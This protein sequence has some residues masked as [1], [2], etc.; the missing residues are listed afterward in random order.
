MRLGLIFRLFRSSA[1]IQRKRM[2]LTVIAIAWGTVSIVMLLAFGEG[3]KR[4][5]HRSSRGTGEG[6]LIIWPGE[7]SIAY[8]GFPA[9][10]G[11]DLL[12]EDVDLL[13][14]SIPEIGSASGEMTRWGTLI[15]YGDKDLIKKITGVH[16]GFGDMR[17]QYA[18]AG[19]RF[20]DR[21]DQEK[22]RRVI[23][24]GDALKKD[25]FGDAPAVG[26]TVLVQNVPFTVVG[27]MI[28]KMQTGMYG[29]P[30]EGQGVVPISTFEALYGRRFLSNMVLKPASP[31]LMQVMKRRTFEVLGSKYRFDPDDERA[32]QTWDTQSTQEIQGK[33][34]LGIEMFLGII[35][36]LTLIIGGVGVANIM[37]A[38][39]QQR[40]SELG[41][42]MALGARRSWV[43][44]P[45]V[46]E[47]LSMTFAGG[48]L[49]LL[50]GGGLVQV[51]GYFQSRATD[52][53]MAFMGRPTFSLPLVLITVGILGAIGFFSGYFPAR[54]ATSIQPAA[55]LRYE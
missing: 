49:G 14:R 41:V 15:R 19:G 32:L 26:E 9:G 4:S 55:V 22:K 10:R 43:L 45:L 11:I 46:L 31:E 1:K 28:H 12:P 20:L 35:G 44:G 40:T 7:T 42:Q 13:V 47:A 34:M 38:V 18:T 37:Y 2:L 23:F 17:H 6:L 24:L 48:L 21:L 51:L 8:A 53:A 50:I 16:P 39:V 36:A 29:G 3:L 5:L 52:S 54:R 27:D 30:D 33:M 25:L